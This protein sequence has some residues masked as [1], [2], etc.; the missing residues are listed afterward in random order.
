MKTEI[1]SETSYQIQCMYEGKLVRLR[2]L[3]MED[4][5]PLMKFIND[6]KSRRFDRGSMEAS[7]QRNLSIILSK[8]LNKAAILRNKLAKSNGILLDDKP[9]PPKG[10]KMYQQARRSLNG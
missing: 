6:Y 1:L 3:E 4:L 9:K 10:N 8:F 7:I 2:A 5:E